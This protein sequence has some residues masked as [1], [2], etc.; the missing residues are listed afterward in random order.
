MQQR[1][2]RQ[3]NRNTE[4]IAIYIHTDGNAI[5]VD[6]PVCVTEAMGH[7]RHILFNEQAMTFEPAGVLAQGRTVLKTGKRGFTYTPLY[8]R[9]QYFEGHWDYFIS[10]DIVTLNYKI[11][12]HEQ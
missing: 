5:I 12:N 4:Y 8:K 3:D 1:R 7:P 9:P 6:I 2:T 11:E 10:G